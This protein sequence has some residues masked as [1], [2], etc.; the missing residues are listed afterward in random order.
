MVTKDAGVLFAGME[1]M[2]NKL[3]V[4]VTGMKKKPYD[5]LDQRRAEFDQDFDDFKRLISELHVRIFV[6]LFAF[7]P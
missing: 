7:F 5:F 2:A 4:I 1:L 6:Q 3:A